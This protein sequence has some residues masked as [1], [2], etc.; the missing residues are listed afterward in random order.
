[1]AVLSVPAIMEGAMTK[2]PT[3]DYI[4]SKFK[5]VVTKSVFKT[6]LELNKQEIKREIQETIKSEL[7]E[8]RGTL[9]ELEK[10]MEDCRNKVEGYKCAF[11]TNNEEI[12]AL[13]TSNSVLRSRCIDLEQYSRRNNIR[14]LGIDDPKQTETAD[15]TTAKVITMLQSKLEMD[16]NINDIDIAHRLGKFRKDGNRPVIVKFLSRKKKNQALYKRRAL[17]G[18]SIVIKEALATENQKLLENVASQDC[19]KTTWTKD[20]DVYALLHNTNIITVDRLTD[21]NTLELL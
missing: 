6:A 21:I 16:V 13:K 5:E 4:D 15:D 7:E 19:V 1:M 11:E 3:T 20:A 2:L 14:I 10:Q 8:M 12:H 9:F 17:K 18:S